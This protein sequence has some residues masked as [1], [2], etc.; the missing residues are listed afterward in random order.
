LRA[1]FVTSGTSK[2]AMRTNSASHRRVT[3]RATFAAVGELLAGLVLLALGTTVAGWLGALGLALVIVGA[4]QLL[5]LLERV[6][7]GGGPHGHP[8]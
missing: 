6:W 2:N 1:D 8:R 7:P 5:M 3:R 4:V